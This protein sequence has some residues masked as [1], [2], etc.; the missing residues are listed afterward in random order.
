MIFIPETSRHDDLD[1]L[2]SLV[3]RTEAFSVASWDDMA[4]AT[5]DLYI[6][7]DGDVVYVEDS[8]IPTIVK[9]KLD[10]PDYVTVSANVVYQPAVSGL[11]DRLDMGPE[12][13]ST[14]NFEKFPSSGEN[15]HA[16]QLSVPD[17]DEYSGQH[18]WFQMRNHRRLLDETLGTTSM[19]AKGTRFD[20]DQ[21]PAVHARRHHA[22]LEQLERGDLR[23]YKFPL[24]KN[25]P[26]EISEVFFCMRGGN[27]ER[28]THSDSITATESLIIDGKGV[29]SHF[30]WKV[31]DGVGQD[32]ILKR[33]RM[34]AASICRERYDLGDD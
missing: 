12:V 16:S 29:V 8:T 10:Y 26:N 24:W 21:N 3:N 2:R 4:Y 14:P 34:Y 18:R 15:W 28:T 6:Y 13:E 30:D 27:M 1:F 23:R 5:N 11:H 9:T 33:Y 20:L 17:G 25:P 7:I 22:F 32:S 31:S 19:E